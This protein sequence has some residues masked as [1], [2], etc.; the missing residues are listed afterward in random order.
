LAVVD[1][2]GAARQVARRGRVRRVAARARVVRRLAQETRV[3]VEGWDWVMAGVAMAAGARAAR[4]M[5]FAAA[6]LALAGM[7]ATG[8]AGV[9]AAAVAADSESSRVMTK[10][11]L[12]AVA[13][14]VEEIWAESTEAVPEDWVLAVPELEVC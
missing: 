12:K 5:A 4:A 7:A 9:A 10:A 11:A 2:A 3:V 13:R 1:R 6:S 14:S 8:V